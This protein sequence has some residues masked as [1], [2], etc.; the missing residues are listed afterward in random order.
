MLFAQLRKHVE[1]DFVHTYEP[2]VELQTALLTS[3]P[4][5]I[6]STSKLFA[7]FD[8]TLHKVNL[9]SIKGII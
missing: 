9:N 8:V 6:V 7:T 5:L 1:N 2:C 3:K 4:N